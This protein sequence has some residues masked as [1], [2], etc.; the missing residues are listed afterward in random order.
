MLIIKE[1]ATKPGLVPISGLQAAM[2]LGAS[3]ASACRVTFKGRKT[4]V[5]D[6][7]M[8]SEATELFADEELI[9]VNERH[10][11]VVRIATL[12][13]QCEPPFVAESNLS[14]V[15]SVPL[16]SQAIGNLPTTACEEEMRIVQLGF[17]RAQAILSLLQRPEKLLPKAVRFFARFPR[18]I[19]E[20][21][22]VFYKLD[23]KRLMLWVP[24]RMWAELHY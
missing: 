4:R 18:L 12:H 7:W 17:A 5:P 22:S 14:V 20:D 24:D 11:E 6:R 21:L 10:G 15:V 13:G 19:S 8:K 16:L 1:Q 2:E 9:G 23:G 3:K